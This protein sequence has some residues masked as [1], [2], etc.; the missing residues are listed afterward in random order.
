MPAGRAIALALSVAPMVGA[1]IAPCAPR[2]VRM[3]RRAP[4]TSMVLDYEPSYEDG[5][6]EEWQ[7]PRMENGLFEEQLPGFDD[8]FVEEQAPTDVPFHHGLRAADVKF[9]KADEVLADN[10]SWREESGHLWVLLFG[11]GESEGI[12]TLRHPR[13]FEY[14]VVAFEDAEEASRFAMLLEAEDFELPRS[15]PWPGELLSEFCTST[16]LSIGLVLR[17]ELVMPPSQNQW[18]PAEQLPTTLHVKSLERIF[19]MEEITS[20]EIHRQLQ[21]MYAMRRPKMEEDTAVNWPQSWNDYV[22][23]H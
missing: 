11:S 19:N 9:G 13:D 16:G 1:V 14:F 4:A 23:A 10:P 8:G 17:G 18:T 15:E 20:P 21:R 2:A 12:Y 7:L 22:D 6:Y 5:F 3:Q